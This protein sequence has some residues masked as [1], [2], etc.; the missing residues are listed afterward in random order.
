VWPRTGSSR[1]HPH[2]LY[3]FVEV[4]KEYA[5]HQEAKRNSHHL[6]SI[7]MRQGGNLKSY[8]NFFQNQLTKISNCG[9]EVAALAFISGLQVTRSFYK[10]LLKHVTK[11]REA[12]FRAQPYIQLEET[13]KASSNHSANPR[14]DGGKPK[15]PRETPDRHGG[16]RLQEAGAPDPLPDLVPR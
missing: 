16:S 14:V 8:L 4:T 12:L 9:E 3:N 1:C 11:M 5:S 7:R 2:S 10:H 6:F 15:I 13:M